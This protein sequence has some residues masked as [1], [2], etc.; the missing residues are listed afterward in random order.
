MLSM[1]SSDS[2]CCI[3]LIED[4]NNVFEVRSFFIQICTGSV[5]YLEAFFTYSND[6]WKSVEIGR[7]FGLLEDADS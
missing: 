1:N 4:Q 6:L 5:N 7:H 2:P 3:S